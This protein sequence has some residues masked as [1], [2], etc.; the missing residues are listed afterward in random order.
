MPAL[1]KE[2]WLALF[3]VWRLHYRARAEALRV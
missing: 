2:E 1:T 3:E